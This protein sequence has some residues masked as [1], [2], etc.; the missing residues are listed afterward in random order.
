MRVV[1]VKIPESIEEC[2]TFKVCHECDLFPIFECE[3]FLKSLL[4]RIHPGQR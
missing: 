2:Q 3:K 1:A 4:K